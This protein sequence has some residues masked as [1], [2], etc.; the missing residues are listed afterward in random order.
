M[1]PEDQKMIEADGW[2]V[3]CKSYSKRNEAKW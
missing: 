2:L 3:E 1:N